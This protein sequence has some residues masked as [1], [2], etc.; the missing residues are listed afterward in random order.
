[1]RL[2]LPLTDY[3]SYKLTTV[4]YS[5]IRVAVRHRAQ[6]L[7]FAIHTLFLPVSPPLLGIKL[8]ETLNFGFDKEN[9]LNSFG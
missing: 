9:I 4:T 5:N 7:D 1:V 8:D 2:C 6:P 3:P